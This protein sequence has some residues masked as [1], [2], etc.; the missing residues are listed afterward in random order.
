MSFVNCFDVASMV[1]E[2]ANVRFA[3]LFRENREKLKIFEGYCE[4]IDTL[5]HEFNGESLTVEVDEE[6]MTISV[7]MISPDILIDHREHIFYEL[8]RRSLTVRFSVDGE[9]LAT[10]FVFPSIWDR[11]I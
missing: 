11:V 7:T 2:E 1:I 9:N 6:L 8:L 5:S 3:P 4:A 10:T